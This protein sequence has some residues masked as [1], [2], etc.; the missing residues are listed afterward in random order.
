VVLRNI[1]EHLC[2]RSLEKFPLIFA[3]RNVLT[4]FDDALNCM[5][6]CFITDEMLEQLPAQAQIGKTS[7]GGIDVNKP[8]MRAVA[9]AVIA[10]SGHPGPLRLRVGGSGLSAIN[11]RRNTR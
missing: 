2:E 7:L 5:D 3:C 4:R 9:E 8:L 6:Q 10:W 11:R 1:V